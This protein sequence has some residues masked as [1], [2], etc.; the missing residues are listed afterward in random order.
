MTISIGRN[1]FMVWTF[2]MDK[3]RD[4]QSELDGVQVS[5]T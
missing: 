3:Q 2:V 5:G 4:R 1:I